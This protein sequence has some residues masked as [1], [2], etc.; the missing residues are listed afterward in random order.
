MN[1]ID[2]YYDSIENCGCCEDIARW[3][4]EEKWPAEAFELTEEE[5]N[6]TANTVRI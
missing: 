3:A 1:D 5:A 4:A 6:D 2:R